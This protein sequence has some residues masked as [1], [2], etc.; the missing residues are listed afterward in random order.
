MLQPPEWVTA[1]KPGESE[2]ERRQ[3][4]RRWRPRV[5][6]EVDW[7]GVLRARGKMVGKAIGGAAIPRGEEAGDDEVAGDHN[8]GEGGG[9]VSGSEGDPSGGENEKA[10][11]RTEWKEPEFLTVGLIGDALMSHLPH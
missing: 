7:E 2:E 4:V 8:G 10:D 1:A 6:R 5:R 11:D 3:R 9:E